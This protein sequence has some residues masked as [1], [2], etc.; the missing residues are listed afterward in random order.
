MREQQNCMEKL[1]FVTSLT[2]LMVVGYGIVGFPCILP[3]FYTGAAPFLV[4]L[5]IWLYWGVKWQL[6]LVDFCYFANLLLYIYLWACPGTEEVFCVV[7][8][9]ANGPLLFAIITYR[10]TLAFHSLDRMTSVFIHILPALTTFAIRWY[11]STSMP[12]Y[13]SFASIDLGADDRLPWEWIVA[14]PFGFYV[15][16]TIMYFTVVYICVKP[17]EQYWDTY[18]YMTGSS[19]GIISKVLNVFGPKY[20]PVVFVTL[21][22]LYTLMTMLIG[23]LW[24]KYFYAHCVFLSIIGL[25]L[26]WNG[27]SFYLDVFSEKGLDAE[28]YRFCVK[29]SEAK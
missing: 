29:P 7:F 2:C 19:G 5:R 10:N 14:V 21:S 15:L 17:D 20:K 4:G 27:A 8:A 26:I 6:F 23:V 24:F 1:V 18:R 28:P 9:V 13:T 16:H 25:V 3:Y 11:P 12:W 22:W